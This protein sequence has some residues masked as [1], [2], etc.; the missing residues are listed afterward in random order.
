MTGSASDELT[1]QQHIRNKPRREAL[2]KRFKDPD[3]DFKIVIVRDMW[4]TGFDAP[5]LHTMYV[6]KP[7]QGHGLMQA[8]ARVNRVFRDKPGGLIVDYIGLAQN[9]REAVAT[10][11]GAGGKGKPVIPIE[12]AIAVMLEKLEILK[13]FFHDFDYR[14]WF[15]GDTAAKLA[16]LKPAA[17]FALGEKDGEKRVKQLASDLSKAFALCASSDEALETRDEVGFFQGV[18]SALIKTNP[19]G[20]RTEEDL[21]AAIRQL[22]DS[23]VQ[24]NEV[25]D[26]FKQAGVEKPDIS[27]LSDEFL[28]GLQNMPEKNL[29]LETLKKLLSGEIRETRKRNIVQARSFAEMLEQAVLRYQN[30][31]IEAAE[32]ISELIELAKEMQKSNRRG[33][34]LGLSDHEVAFYDALGDNESAV[35]MGDDTLKKIAQELVASIRKSVTV[36]WTI[37]ESAQAHMRRVIKRLLR[38]YNYP[39][40]A[41]EAAVKLVIEQAALMGEA[42]AA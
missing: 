30:R 8:I 37:R 21:E 23:A 24:P 28:E 18:R 4:L 38:K 7:M 2:A 19:P 10:Y 16:L 13:D 22:V 27:I 6:D 26:I 12:D 42:L 3:T 25:I 5:C 9:L 15:G 40:D 39:P 34:S 41:Q 33:E 14:A 32:V 31:S 11:T 20:E 1:W 29:A 36:D 17:D 35:E